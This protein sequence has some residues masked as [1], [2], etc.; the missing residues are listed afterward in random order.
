[1]TSQMGKRIA[2]LALGGIVAG[3][4]GCGGTVAPAPSTPGQDVPV[5][6]DKVPPERTTPEKASCGGHEH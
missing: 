5:Q 6:A 3:L 4:G 1:M 2:L